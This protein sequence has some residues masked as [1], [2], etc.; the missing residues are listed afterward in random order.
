[1]DAKLRPSIISDRVIN[2]LRQLGEVVMNET[3][4]TDQETI[5]ALL[6]DADIAVTSWGNT[7]MTSE[8][9]DCAPNL[10]LVAHAAGSVKSIASD[11]LY[12]RGILISSCARVLSYGVSETA[13]GY[14]I[15]AAKDF[16]H[17][18][19]NITNG[20]WIEDYSTVTELFDIT[21]GVVSCGFAGSHYIELLQ[22]FDVNVIAYDPYKDSEAI[23]SLGARKVELEELIKNSDI[24]SLHAPSLDSTHHMINENTLAMMKE[25][26]I[27]INT[28]RGSLIDEDAL[29]RH[30]TKGKLK[31]ACLDVTDPEPPAEDNPLRTLPNCIMTPHIAGQAN[32]GKQKIGVH[33]YNEITRLLEGKPLQDSITK[34]M[35]ATIA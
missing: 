29:Y 7:T 25:N 11:E 2:N 15:T 3:D 34:E 22:N 9:L 4:G 23:A 8:L 30:M 17:L 21:V 33:V 26:A 24:I 16:Y 13:L 35:L 19:N 6:K 10:K 20:N 31:Y 14:T 28:A 32:N 12:E 1:M 18:N 27:L 5:K